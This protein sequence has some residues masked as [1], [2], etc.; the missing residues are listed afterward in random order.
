MIQLKFIKPILTPNNISQ[1]RLEMEVLIDLDLEATTSAED[2][3]TLYGGISISTIAFI[4]SIDKFFDEKIKRILNY[5]P[6]LSKYPTI[7][8][9]LRL[10]KIG[11][12]AFHQYD[13]VALG[14][15]F[16]YFHIGH[17]ILL[18]YAVLTA[19]Q[20]VY[21]GVT[22]EGLLTK[23]KNKEYIQSLSVRMKHV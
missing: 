10:Q 20:R 22:G 21:I 3:Q 12:T 19:N 4:F 17:Q 5:M 8:T 23:K 11:E 15:T 16:D 14:G 13:T 7:K 18:L 9:E 2:I 1:L 6:L